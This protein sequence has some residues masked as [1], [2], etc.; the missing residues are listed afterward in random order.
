MA[1]APQK[2]EVK[3]TLL[4]KVDAFM[5]SV[6]NTATFGYADKFAAWADSKVAGGSYQDHLE[7][8]KKITEFDN[9]NNSGAVTAGQVAGVV[10]GGLAARS[11]L[12]AGKAFVSAYTGT[13]AATTVAGGAATTAAATVS[14]A[15]GTAAAVSAT[16]AGF[17]VG[18]VARHLTKWAVKNP[19]QV[20]KGVGS[21]AWKGAKL[22]AQQ[23]AIIGASV[24]IDAGVEAASD[25]VIGKAEAATGKDALEAD[26]HKLATAGASGAVAAG[27]ALAT[28]GRAGAAATFVK[29]VASMVGIPAAF[30]ATT[31]ITASTVA[32]LE[33]GEYGSAARSAGVGI[34]AVAAAAVAAKRGA[35]DVK[36]IWN[37][38]TANPLVTFATGYLVAE[39]AQKTVQ[40]T[41]AKL[42]AA[43]T[44]TVVAS[45]P[46]PA[47]DPVPEAPPP[48]IEEAKPAA[49]QHA[50]RQPKPAP[51]R[52]KEPKPTELAHSA[53]EGTLIGVTPEA[54]T[55]LQVPDVSTQFPQ[56]QTA[57]IAPDY[58]KPA[59]TAA[60]EGGRIDVGGLERSLRT[61]SIPNQALQQV[62]EPKPERSTLVARLDNFG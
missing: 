52:L 17:A 58:V 40:Q 21:L 47:A 62:A 49:E 12:S 55:G 60:D 53:A 43:A 28:R 34:T 36:S 59:V 8:Q 9:Q 27:L 18:A 24:G 51:R 23:A 6:A 35:L 5:R 2:P 46:Q 54:R 4:G 10:G 56:Q 13:A 33:E 16:E 41:Q 50:P 25:T 7:Q 37:G 45:A 57:D 48:V 26:K 15:E 61:D 11:V 39:E 38:M 29:G 20:A 14:G 42:A 22:V 32:S 3:T 30:A 19:V 1:D 44:P 31:E